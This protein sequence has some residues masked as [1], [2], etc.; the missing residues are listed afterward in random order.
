MKIKSQI[1]LIGLFLSILPLALVS[2]LLIS[3]YN[4]ELNRLAAGNLQN[5]TTAQISIIDNFFTEC[6][7]DM[8]ILSGYSLFSN[9]VE[10]SNQG[11][12]SN[13]EADRKALEELFLIQ[14]NKR[15]FIGSITA[16][17]R[18]FRLVAST[19]PAEAGVV[20]LLSTSDIVKGLGTAA[21]FS[22]IFEA[23]E[24]GCK[25]R[26]LVA[27]K[28]VY[29]EDGQIKGYLVEEI[30]LEYFENL[31]IAANLLENGTIYISDGNGRI[32]TAGSDKDERKEYVLDKDEREEFPQAW[33]NRD[34]TV[35][36]GVIN[37]S[38]KGKTYL[39]SYGTMKN[40]E[41]RILSTICLDDIM[42]TRESFLRVITVAL[43]A[44][45]LLM[46]V[47]NI[48]MRRKL[49]TPV[50]KMVQTFADIRRDKDFSRRIKD[51]RGN[52]MGTVASNINELLDDIEIIIRNQQERLTALKE[53]AA[54]DPLTGLF[55]NQEI[56]EIL[57]VKLGNIRV[58]K[59]LGA[60]VLVDIDNF[61]SYNT[62]YG[63]LGG[64]KVI[65][66]VA[67]VMKDISDDTAGRIGG[68]EFLMCLDH[69]T[70]AEDVR[71]CMEKL[72]ACLREGIDLD[73]DGVKVPV[74]CSI[75]VALLKNRKEATCEIMIEKADQAMYMVKNGSKDS[76]YIA[77]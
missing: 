29:D 46:I 30:M 47:V 32:I 58:D 17:D 51:V 19:E 4:T 33:E 37:Y 13:A 16:L 1:F 63:H 69:C 22:N 64:D 11:G 70:S 42:H 21:R 24:Y 14:K 3:V 28:A 6:D 53:K 75:G 2:G 7:T 36:V 71:L 18:N 25:D 20:S 48:V 66:F 56:R 76:Y 43:L 5:I 34:Q 52:E 38:I 59:S 27:V 68:D 45:G 15:K 9:P 26:C 10:A 8:S 65:Q 35:S 60:C 40:A 31:R 39:S 67:S 74:P 62:R 23:G 41:W 44:T 72:A 49:T 61:K 54:R 57:T 50:E 77:E 73:G 12:R 55:N